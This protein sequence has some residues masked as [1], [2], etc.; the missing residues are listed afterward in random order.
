M[1]GDEWP[2]RF[3]T[4]EEALRLEGVTVSVSAGRT[5]GMV[6]LLEGW[7]AH[8]RRIEKELDSPD[9]DRTV[10]G[11]YDLIAAYS[12]R[13]FIARGIEASGSNSLDGFLRALDGVDGVL[14]SYTETDESGTVRRIDGGE[15]PG[16]EWWW[17]LVPR[18]GPI[19]REAENYSRRDDAQ[20]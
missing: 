14:R 16:S 12:L 4:E 2:T 5:L 6:T 3:L 17:D 18:T 9:S 20:P 10:W 1:N 13:S 11:I 8:V 19:R 7:H 15:R